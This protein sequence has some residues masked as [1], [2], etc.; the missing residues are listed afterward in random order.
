MIS[1]ASSTAGVNQHF[2]LVDCFLKQANLRPNA[3]AVIN[4]KRAISYA[5][6]E[7]DVRGLAALIARKPQAR[8][9]IAAKQGRHAYAAMLA[10]GLAGATYTAV[11]V[12]S[13]LSKLMVI[14]RLLQPDFIVSDLP[15]GAGLVAESGSAVLI[16]PQRVDLS[17]RIEGRGDRHELAYIAFTSGSTGEPKGVCIPRSALHHYL[18]WVSRTFGITGSDRLS[19]FPNIGFDISCTDIYGAL[20]H[21]AAICPPEDEADRLFVARFLKKRQVTIFNGVPSLISL[22][23]R[24]G[25]VTFENLASVRLF[26][27]CGEPLLPEHLEAIFNVRPDALVRNTYGPTEAT[28]AVT[29]L[30][31]T[32]ENYRQH[33]RHSVSIGDAIPGTEIRPRRRPA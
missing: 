14:V 7:N 33:C 1:F 17:Y 18:D 5:E 4:D 31:L 15:L 12:A 16:D 27:F 30:S 26:N 6:L 2:E 9:L 22:M 21:G 13:P 29:H 19:Q 3:P 28:V 25:D 24:T 32:K 20:C 10:A 8:V 11:N 23:V